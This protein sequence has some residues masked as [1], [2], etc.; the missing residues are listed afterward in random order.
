MS[1]NTIVLAN[2][3]FGVR[4]FDV[5]GTS[6]TQEG[7]LPSLGQVMDCQGKGSYAY[8]AALTNGLKILDISDP[9]NPIVETTVELEGNANGIFVENSTAYIAELDKV[10]SSG[11]YLE[12]VDISDTS[13]PSIIGTLTLTGRPFDLTVKD[14]IALYFLFRLKGWH[15]RHKR[16]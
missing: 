16:S 3:N 6:I 11:G 5:S 12:I 13:S 10:E 7:T 2:H 8:V 4:I 1:G 14:N 9:Q 15:C